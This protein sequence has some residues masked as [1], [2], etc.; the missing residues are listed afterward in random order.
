[1]LDVERLLGELERVILSIADLAADGRGQAG[2]VRRYGPGGEVEVRTSVRVGFLDEMSPSKESARPRPGEE[3]LIDVMQTEDA[4]KVL[5]L[6]PGVKKDDIKVSANARS[7]DF[8]INT[9]GR[10]Y[11][12]KVPL[13]VRPSKIRIQS[14]VEN[15]SV[16][17]ITF[18]KKGK[19]VQR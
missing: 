3:P 12:K 18:S 10:T 14:I 8:E 6:L 11:R 7:L 13:D 15:N 9:R 19:A 17:E 5:V 16:V 4:L 2:G 1:M